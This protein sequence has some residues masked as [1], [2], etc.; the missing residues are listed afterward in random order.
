MTKAFNLPADGRRLVKRLKKA[1]P[2]EADRIK[3]SVARFL[4]AEVFYVSESRFEPAEDR[5]EK[6]E[7]VEEAADDVFEGEVE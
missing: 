7:E 4:G 2:E 3:R 6:V 1:P 5:F